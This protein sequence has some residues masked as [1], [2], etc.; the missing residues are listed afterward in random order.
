MLPPTGF[1]ISRDAEFIKQRL[2]VGVTPQV[3]E[4]RGSRDEDTR[5]GGQPMR[6]VAGSIFLIT[7]VREPAGSCF[8]PSVVLPML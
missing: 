8:K 7:I 4:T 3:I 1:R 2:C 6:G 5:E